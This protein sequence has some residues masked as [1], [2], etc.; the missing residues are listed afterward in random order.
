MAREPK[1]CAHCGRR[2]E[3]RKMSDHDWQQLTYCSASCRRSAGG[4]LHREVEEQIL[5][6]LADRRPGATICPSEA[7]KARFG[8]GFRERM[9]LTRR[10]ARRL[11]HR[12][13]VEITQKGKRVDPADF[14]G[15]I[16]IG[17]GPAYRATGIRPD[18]A[19]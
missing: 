18:A 12:G 13:I 9:E 16:R 5:A 2:I 14:S 6:L 19:V 17:R 15:P 7:A 11:A 1:I 10:A 3:D 4:R 8:E